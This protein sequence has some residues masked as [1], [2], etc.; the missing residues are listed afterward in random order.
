MTPEL[1]WLTLTAIL[2]ASLWIP[3]I[4]GVNKYPAATD[5]FAR[6]APL[7]DFPAWVHRAHRAHLNLIEQAVPFA[8]VVIVAHLAGVSNTVTVWAAA[9]F[10]W[11][12]LAHAAGMITGVARMP[13]RPLIFTAGWLCILAIAA[14]VLIA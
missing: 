2:A 7:S 14:A 4:V 8:I 12:R 6:P 11:L 9:A 13:L 1:T 5:A 10:F 3:Y